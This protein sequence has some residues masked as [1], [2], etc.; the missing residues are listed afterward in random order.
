MT[1]THIPSTEP[2]ESLRAIHADYYTSEAVFAE[3]K[4]KLFYKSWQYVCHVSELSEPGDYVATSILGQNVFAV[5][6][7]DDEVPRLL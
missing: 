1:D 4:E 2:Q 6:D 5:R 3:E 7:Q